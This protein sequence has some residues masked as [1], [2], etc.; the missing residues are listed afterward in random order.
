MPQDHSVQNANAIV[1]RGEE[2]HRAGRFSEAESHYRK[3]LDIAPEHAGALYLLANIA[4]ADGRLPIASEL[5]ERLLN[6]NPNEARA[7]NLQGMIAFKQKKPERGLECYRKAVA[8]QPNDPVALYNLGIS[9]ESQGD[10]AGAL[11]SLSQAVKIHPRFFQ[12]HYSIGKINRVQKRLDE[13]IA[14]FKRAISIKPDL[15]SVYDDLAQVLFAQKKVDEV[16]ELLSG[17]LAI[18]VANAAIHA[19]LGGAYAARMQ[20]DAAIFHCHKALSLDASC[21]AAHFTLGSALSGKGQLREAI[22]SYR[23]ARAINSQDQRLLEVLAAALYSIGEVADAIEVYRFWL[24]IEPKNPVAIHHLAACLGGVVP[25]RADDSYVESTFDSFADTFDKVLGDL[26]Y[27]APQLL[28]E[29][30][31]RE[32][33]PAKKQFEI[34]DAGCGTGLCGP[35]ISEYA[36]RLVGVDLSAHML[37]KAMQRGGYDDLIKAELTEF[38]QSCNKSYD[39]IL[40]ADTFVYFG[41]LE[42]LLSAARLA[43]RDGGHLFFSVES[44]MSEVPDAAG[45]D[46][47]LN[48]HGRYSHRED[49]VRNALTRAGFINIQLKPVTLRNESGCPVHGVVV[50]SRAGSSGVG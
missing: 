44:L 30:L 16:I 29:M 33:G 12:A 48:L 3:A 23:S 41:N 34:L 18:N 1:Q 40:S 42:V 49:Y 27:Q 47:R 50:A 39:L 5:V 38:L 10:Y 37:E 28:T 35:L 20:L 45:P 31:R 25:E 8:L 21:F 43:L 2:L 36:S 6:H 14:S 11:E 32:C 22:A 9:L 7:W 26:G 19:W 4:F 15:V 24:T 13:A 46:Y 17:A